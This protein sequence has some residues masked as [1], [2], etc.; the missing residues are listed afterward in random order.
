MGEWRHSFTVLGLGTRWRCEVSFTSLVLYLQGLSLQ[1]LLDRRLVG[2][3]AGLDAV[4]KRKISCHSQKLN[5]DC[6]VH[7]LVTLPT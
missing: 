3:R 6:S 2:L 7:S 5:P 1:Y 4:R